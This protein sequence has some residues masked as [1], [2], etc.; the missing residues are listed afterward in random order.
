MGRTRVNFIGLPLKI[1]VRATLDANLPVYDAVIVSCS[2][3]DCGTIEKVRL[4]SPGP[5]QGAVLAKPQ[6][7]R[8][9]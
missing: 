7:R 9:K 2:S 8:V 6:F 3:G 5:W 1:Q 4:I